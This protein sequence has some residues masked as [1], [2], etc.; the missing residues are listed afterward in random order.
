MGTTTN[1]SVIYAFGDS[2]SDAGDAYLLTGSSLA[3]T[4]NAVGAGITAEPVSPP[5]YAETYGGTLTADVFS[6]GPVA[7]QNLDAALGLPVLGPATVGITTAEFQSLANAEGVPGFIAQSVLAGLEADGDVSNGYITIANGAAGGTDFAIGGAVTGPTGE[8]TDPT[9][10]LTDL[11]AQLANFDHS[12]TTP[13]AGALATVWIGSN[14][15]L[16]ILQSGSFSA[17]NPGTITLA[18]VG[19][20][21]A[22]MD[23]AQSVGNEI[24]FIGSLIAQ[25]VSSVLVFDLPNLGLVPAITENYP[26]EVATATTLSEDYNNLLN[27]ALGTL[28]TGG[29]HIDV[30]DTFDEIDDAIASPGSFG[31]SNVTDPVYTGSFTQ[32]NGSIVSTVGSIQD[33][34]LFFDHEHPTETGQAFT[35]LLAQDVLAGYCF[36]GGTLLLTER[37]EVAV[38][39]LRIGDRM[40]VLSGGFQ[41]VVW[42]GRREAVDRPVCVRAGAFGPGVPARDVFVSPDHGVFVDG[43][44]IPA[45]H[46]V[47]G[48]AVVRAPRTR[49]TYFHV[50]LPRHDLLLASGLACESFLDVDVRADDGTRR[51]A[52][53]DYVSRV[54]EAEGCAELVV[55]GPKLDAARARLRGGVGRV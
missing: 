41:P 30:V 2:L 23:V 35:A 1:Y 4:F 52:R 31:L 38:E 8:E 13:A 49:V 17:L 50:E 10:G 15:V 12:V 19:S 11:S 54:W 51:P 14:D 37:G 22:G 18:N 47:D 53:A 24:A 45:K 3:A 9:I 40:A 5:Y 43:V 26:T 36:A 27:A 21:A 55:T 29:V 20:T 25:G 39:G 7:V 6:N 46:L 28:D 33:T 34:Y 44:L 16:D 32:D 42:L 48:V